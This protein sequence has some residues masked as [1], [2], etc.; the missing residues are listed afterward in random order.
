M[1]GSRVLSLFHT[2]YGFVKVGASLYMGGG[3]GRWNVGTLI[4]DI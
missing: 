1:S 3:G 4:S 2:W